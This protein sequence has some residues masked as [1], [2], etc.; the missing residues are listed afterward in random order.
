MR[1]QRKDRPWR[2]PYQHAPALLLV[3]A[4]IV[5]C[6]VNP[7]TGK[8]QLVLVS[9]GD[10][11]AMGRQAHEGVITQLGL[12]PDEEWQGHVARLGAELAAV[13]ERP[14]LPWTFKVI[15]DPVV[16]A[17]A[18]PGGFIYVTRG[19][20]AHM[21]AESELAGILGHEIGHVTAR[22]GVNQMSKGLLAQLGLGVG[23]ILS[24]ELASIAGLADA[25]LGLLFLKYGRDDE[26]QAD[27]L[28]FRYSVAA[29][30]DPSSLIE[31]FRVLERVSAA[32]G[33]GGLPGWLQTH[34]PA[35]E[36]QQ[37]MQELVVASD[38][39]LSG[40]QVGEASFLRRLDGLVYGPDPRQGYFREGGHFLHPE[41]AFQLAFPR[42]WETRNQR[43]EVLAVSPDRDAVV[44]LTLAPESDPAAAARAF[45]EPAS[46]AAGRGW[47]TRIGGRPVVSAYFSADTERG[48]LAG[49]AA[50]IEHRRRVF[51]LLAYTGQ[52]L[53]SQHRTAFEASLESFAEVR[54]PRVLEV[55]PLRLQVLRLDRARTLSDLA[56]RS[57][58]PVDA[59]K[60]A[61]LNNA[62]PEKLLAAGSWVKI[63]AG[64]LPP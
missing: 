24:P 43:H 14:E 39:D 23:S 12:Y 54:D 60:L 42:G 49:I 30:Y 11:I 15:D 29:G 27:R 55:Q 56:R 37:L 53:F 17:F 59:E 22:H 31:V 47:R 3:A 21:G 4:L 6:S 58:M 63:V 32:S 35:R 38:V 13:A 62:D 50:F 8:R 19:I 52:S 34:P 51:R 40:L 16:N 41:L 33:S 10:E 5:S 48:D 26:R 61:L 25:G 64:E 7:A 57:D 45:F 36:R 46:I 18:L 28:G 9:E 20:L 1:P 2:V 44:A